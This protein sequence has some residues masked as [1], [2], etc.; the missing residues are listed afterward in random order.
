MLLFIQGAIIPLISA[1]LGGIKGSKAKNEASA[2]KSK[3][4]LDKSIGGVGGGGSLS[5]AQDP[6]D[7]LNIEKLFG[8]AQDG[9]KNEL[10]T[11]FLGGFKA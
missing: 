6:L 1:I 7:A 9:F 5:V 11:T 3:A 10:D 2:A 8:Q 4:S